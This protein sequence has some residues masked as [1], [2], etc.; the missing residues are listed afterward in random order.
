M[1]Q[2]LAKVQEDKFKLPLKRTTKY[3]SRV[4]AGALCDAFENV[5]RIMD[6]H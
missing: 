5:M 4:A 3:L 2:V 1:I 6:G